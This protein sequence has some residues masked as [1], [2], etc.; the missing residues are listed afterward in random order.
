[1]SNKY[2]GF[3]NPQR[4]YQ[5]GDI[6]TYYA[7]TGYNFTA[8]YECTTNV[9]SVKNNLGYSGCPLKEFKM[10]VLSGG[11][12][13]EV[14]QSEAFNPTKGHKLVEITAQLMS[15]T[16]DWADY[17]WYHP[18]YWTGPNGNDLE[19]ESA[20]WVVKNLTP[21]QSDIDDAT[22]DNQRFTSTGRSTTSVGLYNT[23]TL[24][25]VNFNEIA[26]SQEGG[27]L[28]ADN[29]YIS[30]VQNYKGYWSKQND[31]KK[32]DIVR[33]RESNNFYYAK[34]DIRNFNDQ[35]TK[36]LSCEVYP[37]DV[38]LVENH[39][40]TL[41]FKSGTGG[42]LAEGFS[43]GQTVQLTRSG[44]SKD[45]GILSVAKL[46]ERIM[47]LSY[48]S[49]SGG[50]F[51]DITQEDFLPVI[52]TAED[53]EVSVKVV[54][55]PET[56]PFL[57][58]TFEANWTKDY[59]IFDPD[60][61]SSVKF[62]STTME[63]SY[64]D[65][66]KSYRPK[67]ANSLKVEF[68]LKF[69]NR[70]SREANSILHFVENKLGQ[71]EDSENK[72]YTLDYNQ[73]I[74]GFYLDGAM[75]FFPY[76]NTENLTRKFYC[77]DFNHTIETEDTHNVSLNIFN[78]TASILNRNDYM[79]VN[80]PDVYDEDKVYRKNDVIYV[81]DNDGYYY[82]NGDSTSRG[83][84][85][86][87][88]NPSTGEVTSINQNIWTREFH[89]YPSTT[90]EVNHSP[91]ILEMSGKTS[92]YTQYFPG[93]K[94]HINLLKFQLKFENRSA[95]E[96]CAILH[97]L[98]SHLGYK[99]FLY[100]PP[101]P[102]NRKRRFICKEWT[103]TYAF[104][105]SHTINANFEQFA[106][107]QNT[108]LDDDELDSLNIPVPPDKAKLVINDEIKLNTSYSPASSKNFIPRAII[109][110]ENIGE[111]EATNLSASLIGD[112]SSKFS[113]SIIGN[114]TNTNPTTGGIT[115]EMLSAPEGYNNEE[116]GVFLYTENGT[117][118]SQDNLGRKA[119]IDSSLG[120]L[121][122]RTDSGS[123]HNSQLFLSSTPAIAAGEKAYIE[124]FA[125]ATEFD[126]NVEYSAK[127][128][129]DYNSDSESKFV[130]AEISS[131]MAYE[132][133]REETIDIDIT[134][135][136]LDGDIYF[137]KYSTDLYEEVHSISPDDQIQNFKASAMKESGK[138][139]EPRSQE[140]MDDMMLGNGA[141]GLIAIGV[142]RQSGSWKYMSDGASFALSNISGKDGDILAIRTGDNA[143]EIG[144][145]EAV[146]NEEANIVDGIFIENLGINSLSNINLKSILVEQAG[147]QGKV[148]SNL[149]NINFNIYG[150]IFS[151][152][153]GKP[154]INSGSGFIANQNVNINIKEDAFIIGKGG[155]GGD[156]MFSEGKMDENDGSKTALPYLTPPQAGERGGNAVEISEANVLVNFT[157][158]LPSSGGVF[159]GGGGG[160]GGN[161]DKDQ[162]FDWPI[163]V[164]SLIDFAGGGGGG[165]GM[166]E[167]GNVLG[168]SAILNQAGDGGAAKTHSLLYNMK[169]GSNGGGPGEDGNG[170]DQSKMFAVSG[171][172]A[173]FAILYYSSNQ[174]TINGETVSNFKGGKKIR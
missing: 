146:S 92:A 62:S 86:I 121:S 59:F 97:F 167:S 81:E 10:P 131:H 45:L 89:W 174:L 111:T 67:G 116:S 153:I 94:V 161:V 14:I 133:S 65:G 90:F 107:G 160:A 150:V 135:A 118:K 158:N 123:S 2:T 122:S 165:A 58:N 110:I 31:Y 99:S 38:P 169:P 88:K 69:S 26:D 163:S 168:E 152:S 117:L 124:I 102:Y 74:E 25:Q 34:K 33:H 51:H 64:G 15:E 32:F 73:G 104:K 134:G 106:I 108:P 80:R 30:S 28:E 162:Y 114:Y 115:Y 43:E 75:L 109:E 148:I 24:E 68:D 27:E 159:G 91:D 120:V 77:F 164:S 144:S 119:S 126:K 22:V 63:Y 129:I 16:V 66:Y 7:S 128:K 173:G 112:T 13:P 42:F 137:K 83:D 142:I 136:A 20:F 21:S 140:E 151:D 145:F 87:Q 5:V 171:G 157:V 50:S 61:G 101:A 82:H 8:F 72:K 53:I 79:Y 98:E 100:T 1:M 95:E 46:S 78:N 23:E 4:N 54:D 18:D 103:H 44:N 141:E 113:K 147:A 48:Y 154:A 29:Y 40:G 127:L 96:A 49:P 93:N 9:S 12:T 47:V 155:R 143:R 70:S 172:K 71:H 52:N 19:V 41:I 55:D 6:V 56:D 76:L 170:N 84:P 35:I 37:P 85:P 11:I 17:Q 149:K 139:A 3:W 105:N 39:I 36:T 156:G 60:Y 138:L 130:E 132:T 57:D 125:T 166:G